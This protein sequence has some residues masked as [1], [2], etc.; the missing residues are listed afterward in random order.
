MASDFLLTIGIPTY[1]SFRTLIVAIDSVYTVARE[2]NLEIIVSDNHSSDET[3]FL[4][5][6]DENIRVI[7]NKTNLGY[8]SNLECIFHQARGKYVKI[9]GD[10]DA[11]EP[12]YFEILVEMLE[13]NGDLDIIISDFNIWNA[14]LSNIIGP[15]IIENSATGIYVSDE[16]VLA[17]SKRRF[18]QVSSLTFR[19]ESW[20][21]I[22]KISAIGMNN[23]HVWVFLSLFNDSKVA[24][25]NSCKLKIR[26]GSPNFTFDTLKKMESA[27]F[28]VITNLQ[29]L[30]SGCSL[31]VSLRLVSAVIYYAMQQ[32]IFARIGSERDFNEFC[33]LSREIRIPI[34]L[35]IFLFIVKV[36]P[37]TIFLLLVKSATSFRSLTNFIRKLRKL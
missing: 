21:K 32:F 4:E 11:V 1:N 20:D 2:L 34:F 26:T 13:L 23:L 8:D 7:R 5:F 16:A 18:G 31:F 35:R 6:E 30:K 10:D 29:V 37:R 17:A 36:L 12:G 3:Q 9:L 15:G 24:I 27:V 22:D 14:D 25:E 19:R 28:S 33:N